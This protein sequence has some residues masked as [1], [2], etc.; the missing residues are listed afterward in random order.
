[1]KYGLWYASVGP[2]SFPDAAAT[3]ATAAESAGFESLWTGEHVAVPA[4]YESEYPYSE[5]GRM[6]GDGA[7]PMAEPMVWYAYVA[8]ITRSIRLVTGILVLPQR[9]PVLVAKQAATLAV[10]SNAN[11]RSRRTGAPLSTHI[12]APNVLQPD[13][14]ARLD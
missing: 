7:I 12:R 14:D 3:V 5:S 2:F 9:E 1:M 10:M 8:A 6:A 11:G 13:R 4:G